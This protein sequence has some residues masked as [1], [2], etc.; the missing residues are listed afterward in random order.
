MIDFA[1]PRAQKEAVFDH[2]ASSWDLEMLRHLSEEMRTRVSVIHWLVQATFV[3]LLDQWE[4]TSRQ[5]A[6]L[7]EDVERSDG[8]TT[9]GMLSATEA[10]PRTVKGVDC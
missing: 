7:P 1:G 8:A 9:V 6:K 10:L 4:L 5:N 3:L 2:A